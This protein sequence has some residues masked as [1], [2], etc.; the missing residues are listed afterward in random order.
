MVQAD[1][2]RSDSSEQSTDRPHVRGFIYIPATI[3]MAVFLIGIGHGNNPM[4]N[5]GVSLLVFV[6]SALAMNLIFERREPP[7]NV[8]R[9]DEA[10]SE[11]DSL[12]QNK[13]GGKS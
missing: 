2:E 13:E 6:F 8:D 9:S 12:N 5:I 3:A 11:A 10:K 1:I 7:S 4:E